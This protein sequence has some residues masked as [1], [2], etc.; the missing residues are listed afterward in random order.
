MHLARKPELKPVYGGEVIRMKKM[1]AAVLA[2]ALALPLD[3]VRAAGG[4]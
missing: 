3:G 2:L 4:L 1:F